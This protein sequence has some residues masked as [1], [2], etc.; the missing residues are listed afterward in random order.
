MIHHQELEKKKETRGTLNA[1]ESGKN[2]TRVPFRGINPY[3]KTKARKLSPYSC[4]IGG[5]F[6]IEGDLIDLWLSLGAAARPQI[7]RY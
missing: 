5:V 3:L 1:F 4:Q 2:L 7:K 6:H